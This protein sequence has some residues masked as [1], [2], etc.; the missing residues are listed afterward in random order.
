[1]MTALTIMIWLLPIIFMIHDFEEIIFVEAWKRKNNRKITRLG[2]NAPFNDLGSTPSFS[3]G[4]L[5][6]FIVFSADAWFTATSGNYILWIGLFFGF[7]AHL[8]IHW[9]M[10]VKF[11][12]Y[13]PGFF[14]AIPFLPISIGIIVYALVMLQLPMLV[15][16]I[17]FTVG[18]LIMLGMVKILHKNM[19]NFEQWLTD[20]SQ[21]K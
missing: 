3:I 12:G 11:H 13:V 2:K 5:L 6:E 19:A 21:E 8:V 7:T 17:S 18:G 10:V 20:W 9:L 4:V 15:V 16:A 1:M 14:T